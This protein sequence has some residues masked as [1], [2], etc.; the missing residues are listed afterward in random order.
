MWCYLPVDGQANLNIARVASWVTA[1][2]WVDDKTRAIGPATW[3][4]I[5]DQGISTVCGPVTATLNHE[6]PETDR[7]K[8]VLLSTT[9]YRIA[10][11]RVIDSD[12]IAVQRRVLRA[13]DGR[14][15]VDVQVQAG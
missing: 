10:A 14:W 8:F 2:G 11:G 3:A 13:D 4:E 7:R 15:L 1:A 5:Q 9:R 12:V 6:G